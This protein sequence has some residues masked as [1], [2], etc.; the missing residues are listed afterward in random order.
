MNKRIVRYSIVIVIMGLI[1][2]CGEEEP[3]NNPPV[4]TSFTASTTEVVADSEVS[5]TTLATDPDG[6]A[7]T[8]T[9]LLTGGMITGAGNMVTWVA[10]GSAGDY[11]ITVDVSDGELGAWVSITITVVLPD[12]PP[13]GMVLIPAGEF[14]MGID[15]SDIP[16][17]VQWAKRWYSDTQSSL[18]QDE[19][20]RH[21]VYLDAFYMD[22]YEVTNAQYAKFMSATGYAAPTRW[23]N[24]NYNAAEQPVVGVS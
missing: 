4:I 14:E 1:V 15:S 20:P 3:P 6:D 13:E 17:L 19:T 21:T 5:L 11:I 16:D 23:S 24:S 9:Y 12:E 7:L 2:G 22:I 8:Y 18:F 10:P